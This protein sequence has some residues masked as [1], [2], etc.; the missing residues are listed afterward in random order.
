MNTQEDVLMYT[1]ALNELVISPVQGPSGTYHVKNGA[2][3]VGYDHIPI[4][5]FS[6]SSHA[7]NI[8]H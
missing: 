6:T 2:I 1:R 4:K 5:N 8:F 3:H 7:W